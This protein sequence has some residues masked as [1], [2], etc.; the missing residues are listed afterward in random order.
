MTSAAKSMAG[1]SFNAPPN[2][3]IAVRAPLTITASL[4]SELLQWWVVRAAA[5]R[6]CSARLIYSEK[7][8][9]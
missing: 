5:Q 7:V 2:P 9:L 1:T 4:M 3:P 6:R 8:I